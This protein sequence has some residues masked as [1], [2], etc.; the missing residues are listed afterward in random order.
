MD[1]MVQSLMFMMMMMI[2]INYL[3]E[4]EQKN[5][6]DNLLCIT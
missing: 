6:L 4:S 3:V 5:Q 2:N 1:Q